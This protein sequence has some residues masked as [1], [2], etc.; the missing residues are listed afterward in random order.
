MTDPTISLHPSG[1]FSLT[2]P[3]PEPFSGS[4]TIQIPPT[5]EGIK[6][7]TTILRAR[8]KEADHRIAQR[9]APTQAQVDAWLRADRAAQEKK[10]RDFVNSFTNLTA[11]DLGL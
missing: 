2:I 8:T 5:L 3:A 10:Q 7:L 11:E 9:S 4:H 6:A 1:A